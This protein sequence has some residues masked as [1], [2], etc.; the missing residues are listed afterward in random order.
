MLKN[1]NF[2]FLRGFQSSNALHQEML[3]VLA[4]I[5]EVIKANNGVESANEYFGALVKFLLF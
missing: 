4:G 5:T 3:A 1:S 2:S